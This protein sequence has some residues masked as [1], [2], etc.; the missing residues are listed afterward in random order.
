[1]NDDQSTTKENVLSKRLIKILDARY[2][3]DQV[4]Y[5]LFNVCNLNCS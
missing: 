3:N 5:L 4:K 2:E 1:M